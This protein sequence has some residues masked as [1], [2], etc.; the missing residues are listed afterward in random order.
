MAVWC[1]LPRHSAPSPVPK[2]VGEWVSASGKH[3]AGGRAEHDCVLTLLGGPGGNVIRVGPR[4]ALGVQPW[5]YIDRCVS[6]WAGGFFSVGYLGLTFFHSLT[7]S[8]S[9]LDHC[10]CSVVCSS[11]H[12]VSIVCSARSVTN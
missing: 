6:W 7:F 12:L 4:V 8:L 3:F 9:H 10:Y 1:L 11:V 5:R 2:R